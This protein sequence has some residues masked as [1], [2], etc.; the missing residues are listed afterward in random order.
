V[1][2]GPQCSWSAEDDAELKRLYVVEG[3]SARQ[4]AHGLSKP[5]TRNAVIGRVYRLGYKRDVTA[6][7]SIAKVHQR[8]RAAIAR[9]KQAPTPRANK[10]GLTFDGPVAP[11]PI[12]LC[13][14]VKSP[15]AKPWLEREPKQCAFPVSGEG[16]DTV[17]CCNPAEA[18]YCPGHMAIAYVKGT[19]STRKQTEYKAARASYAPAKNGWMALWDSAA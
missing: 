8:R 13:T 10:P 14:S 2:L 3:L 1:N 18:V 6:V 12:L 4:C 19:A 17:S 11:T 5:R 7:P 9:N 16:T 15:N